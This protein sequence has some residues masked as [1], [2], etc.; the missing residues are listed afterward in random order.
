MGYKA[1][2]QQPQWS[3]E[4]KRRVAERGRRSRG[5]HRGDLCLVWCASISTLQLTASWHAKKVLEDVCVKPVKSDK[6][7][8]ACVKHKH[9]RHRVVPAIIIIINVKKLN[10]LKQ[11]LTA[12]RPTSH[13]WNSKNQKGAI[14]FAARRHNVNVLL[15]NSTFLNFAVSV[16]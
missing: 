16:V 9:T 4:F 10:S 5:G 13:K 1:L 15:R 2:R 3:I 14:T 11:C 7:E 8:L 12:T 6:I